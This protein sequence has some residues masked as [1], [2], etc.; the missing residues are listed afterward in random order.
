VQART[1]LMA[2]ERALP[3]VEQ[4]RVFD[5]DIERA[6]RLAHEHP[7]LQV[8]DDA[9]KAVRD[10][11][12]VVAATMAAEP[13]VQASWLEPGS[14]FLSVSSLDITVEA[15]ASA[16]LVV[17]DDLA[18]ETAHASRPLARLA[19]AGLLRADEVVSLGAVLAGAHP[20]RTSDAQ[21]IVVSAVGLGIEDVA[22]ATRV[23]RRA[24]SAGIGSKQRLW[25]EP[26]WR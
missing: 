7:P 20:G 22:E 16:D 10:A 5:V 1:Q 6:A 24:E 18:H 9:E 15:L 13:F 17:T 2:L 25:D 12:V 3:A 26:L 19:A 23:L 8:L 4:M 21:R 11:D 14:L